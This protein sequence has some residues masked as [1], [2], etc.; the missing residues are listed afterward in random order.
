MAPFAEKGKLKERAQWYAAKASTLEGVD[1]E[2]SAWAADQRKKALGQEPSVDED[3]LHGAPVTAT[4]NR[5]LGSRR[6]FMVA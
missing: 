2:I 3:K 6:R 5:E 1:A 4:E